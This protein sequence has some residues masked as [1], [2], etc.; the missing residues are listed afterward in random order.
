MSWKQ[1]IELCQDEVSVFPRFDE[2][3]GPG[4]VEVP[5]IMQRT[6]VV[7]KVPG[8]QEMRIAYMLATGCSQVNNPVL[9]PDRFYSC[10]SRGRSAFNPSNVPG[11]GITFSAVKDLEPMHVGRHRYIVT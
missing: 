7:I 10:L 8:R 2:N 9:S 3:Q 1:S 4:L 11:D 6:Y 5:Y